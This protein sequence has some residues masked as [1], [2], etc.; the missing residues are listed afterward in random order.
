MVFWVQRVPLGMWMCWV[1][2]G[3][4]GLAG[5]HPASLSP[6]VGRQAGMGQRAT[7]SRL[8]PRGWEGRDGDEPPAE[9]GTL[10]GAGGRRG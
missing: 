1:L 2:A 7:P 10:W 8:S 6:V 4:G 3:A 5:G 9:A